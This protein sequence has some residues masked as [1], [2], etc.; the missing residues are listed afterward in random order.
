[1]RRAIVAIAIVSVGGWGFCAS[2]QPAS[3]VRRGDLEHRIRKL[4]EG[5]DEWYLPSTPDDVDNLKSMPGTYLF[6]AG[7]STNWGQPDGQDGKSGSNSIGLPSLIEVE[8]LRSD[9]WIIQVSA[10][11]LHSMVLTSE[12]RILTAGSLREEGRGLGRDSSNTQFEAVTEVY[13][14]NESK[15]EHSK[16]KGTYKFTK[17]LGSQHFSVALDD[18]GRVFS[19]G[20]NS[21]GQLCLNDTTSRDRF[22]QVHIPESDKDTDPFSPIARIVDIAG[23]AAHA[24]ASRRWRHVGLWME[25]VRSDI[26]RDQGRQC[27]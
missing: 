10:G 7:D 23:R 14:L 12:G 19:T 6:G 17:V 24:V 15:G 2:A 4:Q 25:S 5:D 9:E 13:E 11:S 18:K 26:A 8:A 22:H 1:M 21:Y 27:A 16:A 20:T 3:L